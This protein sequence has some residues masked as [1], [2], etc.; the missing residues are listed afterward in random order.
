[1]ALLATEEM[2]AYCF[3]VVCA[4]IHGKSIPACPSSIP[5]VDS[6]V[7]ITFK[8]L[9]SED[10]RGCIGNFGAYPLHTQLKDYAIHAAFD[11][12]RFSPIAEKELPSLECCV[13]LLHSFEKGNAWDDWVVGTHGVKL[14]Y[15]DLSAT[16]LPSV[17]VELQWNK[18]QT[19]KSLMGK[20]GYKGTVDGSVLKEI[21]IKRYQVSKACISYKEYLELEAT[22]KK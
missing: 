11:D 5:N 18:E 2:C 8:K 7:F 16:Y 15:R 3:N 17:A 12:H 10:L 9:P 14:Q 21:S 6:P 22:K 20:A 13:S 4:R 19:I 1:M